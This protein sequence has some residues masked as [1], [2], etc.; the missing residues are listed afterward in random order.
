[1]LSARRVPHG[2]NTRL[3]VRD[4]EG[5][6]VREIDPGM[7][8][9]QTAI[10]RG[11]DVYFAGIDVT[12]D[13]A[14][15]LESVIDRG[16]WVARGD[17]PPEPIYAPELPVVYSRMQLSPDGH[18]VGFTRCDE[19]CATTLVG[20]Q[21]GTVLEIPKPELIALAND[22]A[23]VIAPNGET[24]QVIAYALADGAEMWRAVDGT[25]FGRYAT[26]DG[27]RF[28]LSADGTTEPLRVEV[29][30]TDSGAILRTVELPDQPG[31]RWLEPSLS[32]DRYAAFLR[33]VLPDVDEGPHSVIVVDLEAGELLDPELMLGDVP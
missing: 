12:Y 14:G 3:V 20:M 13:T 21:S 30:D 33:T 6:T 29:F 15:S 18:T 31:L 32:T 28:V 26:T 9:A 19:D 23:L 24:N 10:V 17:A 2:T 11:D 8:V 7:Q 27:N 22:A 25:Y 5:R 16:A 1:M 4:L